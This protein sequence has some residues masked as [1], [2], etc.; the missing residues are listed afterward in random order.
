MFSIQYALHVSDNTTLAKSKY[1]DKD[2]LICIH[3]L[4]FSFGSSMYNYHVP[5]FGLLVW[6]S[7]LL[8]LL[9]FL[10][11]GTHIDGQKTQMLLK[12]WREKVF[13]L[14]VQLKSE[15]MNKESDERKMQQ[16]V[17]SRCKVW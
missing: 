9:F 8:I 1:A 10:C 4:G 13:S 5:S 2:V 12:R 11:K 7:G 3:V 15:E 17:S 16:R 14:M 6:L